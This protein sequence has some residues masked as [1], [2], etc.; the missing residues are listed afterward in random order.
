MTCENHCRCDLP[1]EFKHIAATKQCKQPCRSGSADEATCRRDLSHRVSRP[2]MS[3]KKDKKLMTATRSLLVQMQNKRVHFTA[4]LKQFVQLT[5]NP[6]LSFRS[7]EIGNK[8]LSNTARSRSASVI[9]FH[10]PRSPQIFIWRPFP[11]LL[12]A[13]VIFSK[14]G[15]IIEYMHDKGNYTLTKLDRWLQSNT[16]IKAHANLTFERYWH[17]TLHMTWR[18]LL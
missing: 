7:A 10:M 4:Q 11:L 14:Q 15:E 6:C 1:H 13:K 2:L 3:V 8:S 12:V 9:K 17:L 18:D 16:K 5:V